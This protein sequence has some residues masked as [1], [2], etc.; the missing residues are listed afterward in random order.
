MIQI[1]KF[2]EQ[3]EYFQVDLR[4]KGVLLPSYTRK[5]ASKELYNLTYNTYFDGIP[6]DKI[7]AILRKYDI[8][9]MNEDGTPFSAIFVGRS[10]D[11]YIDLALYT[12]GEYK[13][14]KNAS[15]A[16]QWYKLES[17]RYEINIYLT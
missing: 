16:L 9:L 2:K 11:C 5:K 7:E 14:I 17:G 4:D 10:S 6:I 15:L 13:R 3:S 8:Y 12:N 1:K